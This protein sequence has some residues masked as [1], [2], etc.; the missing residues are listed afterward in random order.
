MVGVLAGEPGHRDPVLTTRQRRAG[1]T[2]M[3]CVSRCRGDRLV[4]GL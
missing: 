4:L 3:A 2:M 1:A